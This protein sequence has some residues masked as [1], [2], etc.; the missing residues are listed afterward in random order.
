MRGSPGGKR[1]S[2][3]S[4]L[5][6]RG[7]PVAMEKGP[8]GACRSVLRCYHARKFKDDQAPDKE[9]KGRFPAFHRAHAVWGQGPLRRPPASS[10]PGRNARGR[11][12]VTSLPLLLGK[13][14]GPHD[15]GCH[16]G[17]KASFPRPPSPETLM[18][19]FSPKALRC[20]RGYIMEVSRRSRHLLRKA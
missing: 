5:L 2:L 18:K 16:R 13:G 12:P 17:A 1:I 20:L 4:L 9:K 19:S 7:F 15:P 3:F 11:K 8:H 10:G 14:W 6:Y